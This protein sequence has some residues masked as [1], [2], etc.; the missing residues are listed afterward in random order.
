MLVAEMQK[1]QTSVVDRKNC[2]SLKSLY[3]W[4]ILLSMLKM[5]S[6][7]WIFLLTIDLTIDFI[8]GNI[9][10]QLNTG[11]TKWK[12]IITRV[13]VYLHALPSHH[14]WQN[15]GK[16]VHKYIIDGFN[17]FDLFSTTTSQ[18]LRYADI[19]MGKVS[20]LNVYVTG[21]GSV[22]ISSRLTGYGWTP[23][24]DQEG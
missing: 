7:I 6:S 15:Y 3:I 2:F 21:R 12:G 18:L 22:C 8:L 20:S 13:Y 19:F 11:G 24:L 5:N 10:I 23:I 1:D 9:Q 16:N 4:S 17:H 14:P